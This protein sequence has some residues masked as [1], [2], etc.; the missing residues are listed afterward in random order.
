MI[1]HTVNQ[2]GSA[3]LSCLKLALPGSAI[4]LLEDGVYALQESE[5]FSEETMQKHKFYVLEE[6]LKARGMSGKTLD[7][8]EPVSYSKF[9]ELSLEYSKV[10]SWP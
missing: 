3:L 4:L 9:V 2:R 10:L 5:F 1:L 7:G 8:F 6:D